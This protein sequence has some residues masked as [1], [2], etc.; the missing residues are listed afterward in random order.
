MH[1]K[2]FWI[3]CSQ[4]YWWIQLILHQQNPRSFWWRPNWWL[5]LPQPRPRFLWPHVISNWPHLG[6]LIHSSSLWQLA[7]WSKVA[8]GGKPRWWW[9]G[10]WVSH[11]LAGIFHFRWH[12]WHWLLEINRLWRFCFWQSQLPT[13][14]EPVPSRGCSWCLHTPNRPRTSFSLYRHRFFS[15]RWPNFHFPIL[16]SVNQW[17]GCHSTHQRSNAGEK[18]PACTPDFH[19]LHFSFL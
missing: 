2:Y 5:R 11:L 7:G 15:L 13:E 8:S 12:I 4:E 1:P 10:Y 19:R 3:E 18:S 16:Y 17:R 6:C 14:I 9:C